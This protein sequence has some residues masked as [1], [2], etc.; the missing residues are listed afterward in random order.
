[1]IILPTQLQSL[2]F[3]V[4]MGWVYGLAY[5]LFNRL[6]YIFRNKI[7]I[8]VLE[9]LFHATFMGGLF[10]GLFTLQYGVMNLYLWLAFFFGLYLYLRLYSLFFLKLFES[11]MKFLQLF[12]RPLKI[13]YSKLFAIIRKGRIKR[14]KKKDAK[15]RKR[16]EKKK[17][18]K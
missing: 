5:S 15:K 14:R 8:Y 7:I 10:A 13:A 9:I 6:F 17:K 3:M 4:F 18:N 2:I 1:M 12:I 16:E 11:L